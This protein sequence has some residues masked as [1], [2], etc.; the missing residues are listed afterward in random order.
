MG[1]KLTLANAMTSPPRATAVEALILQDDWP[2][3]EQGNHY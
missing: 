1:E 3:R 2:K